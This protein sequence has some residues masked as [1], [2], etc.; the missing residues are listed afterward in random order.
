MAKASKLLEHLLMI[1]DRDDDE[2]ICTEIRNKDGSDPILCSGIDCD[3]CLFNTLE[4]PE[5]NQPIK[6][7]LKTIKTLELITDD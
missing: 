3:E 1:L 4:N 2:D 7:I 5:M 6:D